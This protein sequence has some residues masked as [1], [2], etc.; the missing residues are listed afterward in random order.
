MD[1]SDFGKRDARGH[2]APDRPIEYPPVFVLPLRIGAGLRWILRGYLL[3]WNLFYAALAVAIWLWASPGVDTAS[4]LQPGWIALLLLRNAAIVA[5]FF[6]AWHMRL[7]LQKRQGTAFKFNAKWPEGKNP[8]FFGGTQLSENIVL[9][10]LSGVTI[11]TAYEVL[12]LWAFANGFF[13]TFGWS[14]HPVYLTLLFL[15]VPLFRELHFYAIHR[16]IHWPP[17]YRRMHRTHHKNTNPS[18]WSGLAMHPAEHLFYF[19]GVL[20]HILVPAHPVIA[21]FQLFH[22]ALTPAQGHSGFDRVVLGDARAM[23]THAYAHYLHHKH[24]ECNYADGVLPLDR[25]FGTFCDGTPQS[26]KAIRARTANP[27]A[28]G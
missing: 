22:A 3:S 4:R 10:F 1:E 2:W 11:W 15:A 12:V 18:P 21:M 26:I 7:Y 8:R 28:G 6:G 16:L 25:W 9:T 23:Q 20:I 19:S 13:A 27:E 5:L 24:F 17:L 14:A